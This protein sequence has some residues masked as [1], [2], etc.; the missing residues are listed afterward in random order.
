MYLP[1]TGNATDISGNTNVVTVSGP[2]LT[3]DH[4]GNANSAYHFDGLN[5][6]MS[7]ALGPGMRPSYP[8]SFSCWVKPISYPAGGVGFLFSNDYVSPG[9]TYDGAFFNLPAGTWQASV[10]DGGPNGPQNRNTK[11]TNQQIPTGS[12]VMLTAVVSSATS[13]KLYINCAEVPGNY[14]G[15]GSGL[16]FTTSTTGS[17]G[18]GNGGLG[19]KFIDADID[20]VRFYNRALNDQEVIALYFY[21]NPPPGLSINLGADIDTCLTSVNLSAGPP[22]YTYSWSNGSVTPSINVQNS[23]TYIVN[24][25]GNCALDSDTINVTLNTPPQVDLGNDTALCL[26]TSLVLDA[27]NGPT[28]NWNTG[29]SNS[30]I[31]VTN[32]GLY[33]VDVSN[34]CGTVRD[35]INI[36]QQLPPAVDLGNDTTVCSGTNITLNA[37]NPGSSYLWNNGQNTQ[38]ITI[39]NPGTYYVTVSNACSVGRDTVV[40][41]PNNAPSINVNLGPDVSTCITNAPLTLDAGNPGATYVWNNN[42]TGQTL[43]ATTAG[44]YFVTASNACFTDR[45]TVTIAYVNPPQINVALG[46]DTTV[47]PGTPLVLN[48]GN[49]GS[50]YLWN[51]GQSSQLLNINAAGTYYVTVSN[52]CYTDRDTIVITNINAAPVNIN[53]GA[54]VSQCTILWPVTL[55]AGNAGNNFIWNT[56][57]QSQS[58]QIN[59]PGTYYVEAFNACFSDIDTIVYTLYTDQPVFVTLPNDFNICNTDSIQINAAYTGTGNILWAPTNETTPVITI[60]QSGTYSV[61]FSNQCYSAVDYITVGLFSST[62]FSLTGDTVLCPNTIVTL[63]PDSSAL[64]YF[65]NDGSTNATLQVTQPGQYW[66]EFTNQHGCIS[67]DTVNVIQSDI[68]SVTLGNDTTLCSAS[69]TVQAL[70]YNGDIVWNTGDTTATLEITQSGTYWLT[71]TNECGSIADTMHV[72]LIPSLDAIGAIPN[73]FTPNNDGI[74]ETFGFGQFGFTSLQ[75][76]M[77]IYNRWGRKVFETTDLLTGWT[78][79]N[80]SEGVYYYILNYVD[81]NGGNTEKHGTITLLQGNN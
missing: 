80:H 46:N 50:T 26:N 42:T 53:L 6:F 71:A 75:G 51:G 15:T 69:V 5:D 52:A 39:N 66:L 54:D 20:E 19:E 59:T 14:N 27:G 76:N 45:D 64:Q 24:V 65:W 72:V 81:C 58:I 77:L 57:Q 35:S 1:F 63:A 60:S 28:Y 49:P 62:P 10:G 55:D 67:F 11:S 48:A 37:G 3:T 22:S 43:V 36:T 78:G 2:V 23:G 73:V 9:S 56:G 29:S 4:F 41:T 34:Q 8:F 70:Q 12:W 47:C 30:T 38:T 21:P 18:R 16:T 33:Y 74:N 31:T 25:T 13:M 61:T 17:I 40:I 68:P 7:I 44:T 32:P 79:E